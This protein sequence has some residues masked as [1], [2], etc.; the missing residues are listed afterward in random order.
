MNAPINLAVLAS[1]DL[2]REEMRNAKITQ[3]ARARFSA[4]RASI[5]AGTGRAT[6]DIS[7]SMQE[8]FASSPALGELIRTALS[9]SA[10]VT[11]KRF[12]DLL[13]KVMQAD[14]EIEAIRDV[15]RMERAAQAEPENFRPTTRSQAVALDWLAA[16]A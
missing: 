12:V 16:G 11:G 1:P 5:L 3:L 6:N 8:F 14:A 7:N 9:G 15:E 13:C 10:E 4:D 2:D